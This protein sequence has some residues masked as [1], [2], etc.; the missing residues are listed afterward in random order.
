MKNVKRIL[1]VLLVMLITLSMVSVFSANDITSFEKTARF[2]ILEGSE[3]SMISEDGELVIHIN[4]EVPIIFEDDIDVREAIEPYEELMAFLDG[5]KLVVTYS[6]TT[7]SIPPQT[8]PEKIV[9]MY[10]VAV[11]LPAEVNGEDGY[12]G[13]EPPIYHFDEDELTALISELNGEIVVDGEFIDAPAPFITHSDIG[14]IVVMVPLR[15]ISEALD[16]DVYWDA[17]TR[18]IRIGAATNLWINRDEYHVG[19]A[20][21]IE[22]GTAPILVDGVTFV[23]MTFFREVMGYT[24][25][26]FEGQVVI[27]EPAE[28]EE[29]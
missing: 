27:S 26:S 20:A 6:I 1:A 21:P 5:R 23:P 18:G 17:E 9:V 7:R 13:I 2:N 11:H 12:M 8:T 25:F 3:Y 22:L 14:A 16:Y 15:A 24:I 19:R 29:M 10:E 28:G 4:N